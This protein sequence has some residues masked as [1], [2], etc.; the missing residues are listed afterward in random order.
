MK[1]LKLLF[2][3]CVM[4]L[5]IVACLAMRPSVPVSDGSAQQTLILLILKAA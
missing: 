5:V 4:Q 1:T 3:L 2:G